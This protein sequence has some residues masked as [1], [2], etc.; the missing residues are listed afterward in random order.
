METTQI[1][2]HYSVE[3][4][5]AR[6]RYLVRMQGG[7]EM[8]QY[9]DYDLAISECHAIENELRAQGHFAEARGAIRASFLNSR[10]DLRERTVDWQFRRN[11]LYEETHRAARQVKSD[12]R[13]TLASSG[14]RQELRSGQL[15]ESQRQ[16]DEINTLYNEAVSLDTEMKIAISDG[17]AE[18][19]EA[20][21][22]RADELL[23]PIERS[24][25][26]PP[27]AG[28]PRTVTFRLRLTPEERTHLD[29]LAS[30]SGETPSQYLRRAGGLIQ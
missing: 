17:D 15:G 30:A 6:G 18:T 22:D 29:T 1:T 25:G 8:S 24:P 13:R 7:R 11:A 23:P 20:C 21:V 12:L 3:H 26:R 5:R 27:M 19:W 16:A 14:G 4:L 28:V 2:E 10:P 9:D